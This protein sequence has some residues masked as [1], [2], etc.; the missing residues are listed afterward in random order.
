[1]GSDKLDQRLGSNNYGTWREQMQALLAYKDLWTATDPSIEQAANPGASQKALSLIKLN[2][3]PHMLSLVARCQTARQA[4]NA[5][6][7]NFRAKS[8][9]RLVQLKRELASLSKSKAETLDQYFDRARTLRAELELVGATVEDN[10]IVAAVLNGLPKSYDTIVRMLTASVDVL[11]LDAIFPR[12]LADE[13]FQHR[14][15]RRNDDAAAYAAKVQRGPSYK[16]GRHAWQRGN[17]PFSRKSRQHDSRKGSNNDRCYNCGEPGHFARDCKKPSN[18]NRRNEGSSGGALAFAVSD[19]NVS[20]A[21]G[22]DWWHIDSAA[23]RH[24]TPDRERFID[25]VPMEAPV[26]VV[27]GNGTMEKAIGVGTILLKPTN[28]AFEEVRITQVYHVPG[29]TVSLISCMQLAKSGCNT[30]IRG[31][32]CSLT[33]SD[34]REWLRVYESDGG[35]MV[36]P[37]YPARPV[38]AMATRVK[39]SAELWHRRM[40][41]LSYASLHNMVKKGAV[42][43]INIGADDFKVDTSKPCNVC[44]IAKQP[45]LPFP[46]AERTADRPLQMVSMD[47]CGPM[48]TQSIGGSYYM[49]TFL[50]HYSSFGVVRFTRLKSEVPEVVMDVLQLM[51]NQTGYKLKAVRTDRGSEYLNDQLSR[52]FRRKGVLHERSAPYTPQQNGKAERLNRTLM[53]RVR[54][55]LQ[56]SGLGQ[57]LWAEAAATACVLRN[58]SLPASLDKTPYELFFGKRP[59][60][61]RLRVFGCPV[62]VHVPKE[63]RH[64]LQPPAEKGFFVGYERGSKAYRV[65]VNGKV[66]IS[67]DVTFDETP[68]TSDLSSDSDDE[69][70]ITPEGVVDDDGEHAMPQASPPLTR[71]RED[72]DSND[73]RRASKR[74]RQAPRQWWIGANAPTV[75]DI[76]EPK[77]YQET[78]ASG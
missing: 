14:D 32:T 52:Y 35:Y 41:H 64:K 65:L 16:D 60:V 31:R 39:E 38:I 61:S 43:G 78:L 45:R 9:A 28:P 49:A 71:A 53:E 12:L 47:I 68:K 54:A 25:Y 20:C 51:E 33:T 24:I 72:W 69:G 8:A 27:F 13:Q 6:E 4:W 29:S 30:S 58:L 50:D 5:L 55:M 70:L 10:D 37:V 57:E 21:S 56:D 62:Y 76:P 66:K 75:T 34:G 18:T 59:D 22:R 19:V 11:T 63:K 40:G 48:A 67:R 15:D 7:N 74:V 46:D 42:E 1:M 26:S 44:E 77:S 73:E 23:S 36:P 3:E 2:L 17:R